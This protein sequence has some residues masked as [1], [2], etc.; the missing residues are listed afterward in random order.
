M[1]LLMSVIVAQLCIRYFDYPDHSS[2]VKAENS[3]TYLYCN[4]LRK[5]LNRVGCLMFTL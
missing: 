4:L 5:R 1:L 2:R 3:N